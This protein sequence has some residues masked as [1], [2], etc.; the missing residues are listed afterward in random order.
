MRFFVTRVIPALIALAI[1]C[2]IA[3]P[4]L[5]STT[6]GQAPI[7]GGNI[8]CALT[9]HEE[10]QLA[11]GSQFTQPHVVTRDG[12]ISLG[13]GPKSALSVIIGRPGYL[14]FVNGYKPVGTP[15]HLGHVVGYVHWTGEYN[16]AVYVRGEL[17]AVMGTQRSTVIRVTTELLRRLGVIE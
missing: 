1:A 7:N 2:G 4:A 12:V 6:P 5:A 10:H 14:E 11:A 17:I 13:F 15:V 16:L 9:S 8:S 3:S